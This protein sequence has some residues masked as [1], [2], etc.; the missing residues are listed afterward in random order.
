MGYY[1]S[2]VKVDPSSVDFTW[3]VTSTAA[4]IS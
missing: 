4:D 2:G 3:K 1:I